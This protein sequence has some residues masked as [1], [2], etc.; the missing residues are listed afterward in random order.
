[1]TYYLWVKSINE[2]AD[3]LG[4][5]DA[6]RIQ[7]SFNVRARKLSSDTFLE[8]MVK[9]L[10]TAGVGVFNTTIF[11]SSKAKLPTSPTALFLT[12]RETGGAPP[13][14]IHNQT[15]PP[16]YVQP[17]LMCVVHGPETAATK[18]K[19]RAAYNALVAVKNVTITP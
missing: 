18:A 8:E 1:M 17:S 4:P 5:D 7:Y 16:A 15:S 13:D 14:S 2:P 10:V 12:L 3:I 19:A 9:V 6:G 11:A